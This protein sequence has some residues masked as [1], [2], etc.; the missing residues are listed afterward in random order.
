MSKKD[1]DI[2]KEDL[3][4]LLGVSEEATEKEVFYHQ[5]IFLSERCRFK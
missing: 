4:A 5:K 1:D 3:Y 2:T